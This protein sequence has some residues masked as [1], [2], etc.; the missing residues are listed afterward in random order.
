[1]IVGDEQPAAVHALGHAINAGARQRRPDRRSTP[2]RSRRDPVDQLASLRELADDMEAGPGRHPVHPRRRTRST[3]RRP[4]S[5]SADRL[6][7]G[8]ACASTS[9][10]TTTRPRPLCH[11]HVPEA[12][13]LESWSDARALDGTATIMQPLIAPL[14]GGRTAHEV[15]G[16]CCAEQAAQSRATTSCG[17]TGRRARRRPR[18]DFEQLL[19]QSAARRRGRGHGALPPRPVTLRGARRRGSPSR[20]PRH[21]LEIVFRPDPTVYDGRFANNGWLQE[22][23]KPLTKLTWDNAALISPATA[24][25]LGRGERGRRR[26]AVSRAHG[27]RRRSGS[28]PGHA[29]DC[30]TVHLGYGRDARRAGSRT[31]VGFN[32]YALRTTAAPWFGRGLEVGEDRR[33]ATRLACT[34]DHQTMEGRAPRP[35]RPRSRSSRQ[36]PTFAHEMARGAAPGADALP[37]ARVPRATR[38]A[39]RST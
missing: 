22:L 19:A 35:D 24:E 39:W 31:D 21:G 10:S 12:H 5:T 27:A 17:R 2:S 20:P 36:N 8:R 38:G 1:M 37:R 11:W 26:A 29:D 13:Y 28:L 15:L 33:D 7:E 18:R 34:Q 9:A 25:R 4:T 14:Y 6:L 23:P 16:G 3:R 32:A 30:V